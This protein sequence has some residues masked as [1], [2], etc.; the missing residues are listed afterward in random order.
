MPLRYVNYECI[1]VP[2]ALTPLGTHNF[3][4]A[5]NL[6]NHLIIQFPSCDDKNF[7]QLHK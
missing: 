2:L 4:L 6:I 1:S 5:L 7:K 3:T